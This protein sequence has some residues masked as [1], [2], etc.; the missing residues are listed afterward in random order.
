[1]EYS[2][3]NWV[4]NGPEDRKE[5]RQAVHII[6]QAISSSSYLK[7]KMIMKGGMLLGIRYQSSRFTEDIDFSTAEK[8]ADIDQDE[9]ESELNEAL[10]VAENELAYPIKCAVQTI[11][12]Q[13]KGG[14]A[15]FPSFN[16]KIGYA[17]RN[18]LGAMRRLNDGQSPKT[19]KIDYSF[20]EMTY[21]TDEIKLEDEE[22]VMTYG[23]TDLLAEKVRSIIQQPYRGR[24]R[25]Q[26][27]YDLHYL[28]SN[29]EALTSEE[30]LNVLNTLFKKSEGRLPL[31]DLNPDTL[32]RADIR[33]MSEHSYHLLA[34]EVIGEL[35]DFDTAY[36]LVVNFYKDLPWDCLKGE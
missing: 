12:I 28:L 31:D 1:M 32:D 7:P 5:F 33:E 35:P 20:N 13:P 4:E 16:L 36:S 34:K 23:I 9:F 3:D 24:N 8:L 17:N 15:T 30:K 2:I 21:K 19:V 26:D 14:L 22:S 11:K 6:L 25:R 27:I 10:Q 18:N 29:I